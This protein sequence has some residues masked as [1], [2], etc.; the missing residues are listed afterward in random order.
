M[1][2]VPIICL[3]LVTGSWWDPAPLPGLAAWAYSAVMLL[4]W[5]AGARQH[6]P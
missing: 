6:F 2:P 4:P 1:A 5:S 3:V